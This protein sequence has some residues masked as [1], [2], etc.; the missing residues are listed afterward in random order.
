MAFDAYMKIEGIPGEALDNNHK[1]WIEILEI[2]YMFNQD[3]SKTS[4][5]AG[6]ATAGRVICHDVHISKYVDKASPKLLEAC[7]SGQHIKTITIDLHRAGGKQQKYL[8]IKL[9]EVIIS[10][11]SAGASQHGEFPSE[12]LELNYG[13][14]SLNYVQQ[15]RIDG[16]GSGSITGGW[17]RV[18]NRKFA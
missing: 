6:G 16:Q 10:S 13:R 12:D 9:E 3:V 11:L 15:K 2:R 7:A 8:S 14:I 18:A 4:S 17:D 1:D 5:S